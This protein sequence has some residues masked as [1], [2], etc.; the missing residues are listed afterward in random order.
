M[1]ERN[2]SKGKVDEA[3]SIIAPGGGG[4]L[5]EILGAIP[6]N[7]PDFFQKIH[8]FPSKNFKKDTERAAAR[9]HFC[10]DVRRDSS[11]AAG[12]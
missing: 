10:A 9:I 3:L 12:S 6:S 1:S 7:P 4:G 11:F 8:K 5:T 2:F